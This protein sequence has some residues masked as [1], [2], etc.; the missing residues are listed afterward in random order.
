[1]MATIARHMLV[2]KANS[3]EYEVL[4]TGIR[5]Q[6]QYMVHLRNRTCECCGWKLNRMSCKHALAC[7]LQNNEHRHFIPPTFYVLVP[8]Y[9][10]LSLFCPLRDYHFCMDYSKIL[11]S[12]Q[13]FPSCCF[14]STLLLLVSRM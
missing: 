13:K 9:P 14:Q 12:S 10:G 2:V 5:R 3:Y 6:R 1:M 4:E 8:N 11:L 7:I